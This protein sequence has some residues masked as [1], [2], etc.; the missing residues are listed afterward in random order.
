MEEDERVERRFKRKDSDDHD[1]ERKS[2]L[3]RGEVGYI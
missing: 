1:M 2:E 3:A